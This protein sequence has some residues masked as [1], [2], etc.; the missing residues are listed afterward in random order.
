MLFRALTDLGP[1][2][3]CNYESS[4]I[5]KAKGLWC[6]RG[7]PYLG[8]HLLLSVFRKTSKWYKLSD[9]F[10]YSFSQGLELIFSWEFDN[11]YSGLLNLF[12][13]E[14]GFDILYSI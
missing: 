8:L 13:T 6:R 9:S 1:V 4:F 7:D 5:S 2:T 14:R 3:H 10:I 11:K 12:D